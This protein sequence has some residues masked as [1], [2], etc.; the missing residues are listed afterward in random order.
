MRVGDTLWYRMTGRDCGPLA[1]IVVRVNED[2]TVHVLVLDD[3]RGQMTD[4]LFGDFK[5]DVVVRNNY[6]LAGP[7]ECAWRSWGG[8]M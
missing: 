8:E 6:E 5:R 1:A 7:G 3:A 4:Q 2:G